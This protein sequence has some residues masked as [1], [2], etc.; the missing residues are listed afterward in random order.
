MI[1][2]NLTIGCKSF[3]RKAENPGRHFRGGQ[4]INPKDMQLA[5]VVQVPPEDY[6]SITDLVTTE[7]VKIFE[8]GC[9]LGQPEE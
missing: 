9:S 4:P 3:R 8:I 5:T 7:E 2:I 6:D 1:I